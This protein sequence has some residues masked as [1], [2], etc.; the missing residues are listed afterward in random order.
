MA[1]CLCS[2]RAKAVHVML[3]L[4]VILHMALMLSYRDLH[5]IGLWHYG[6][7]HY[8]K[9]TQP[10]FILFAIMLVRLAA[11]QKRRWSL[12]VAPVGILAAFSWR[13]SLTP[14]ARTAPLA[15]NDTIKLPRLDPIDSAIILKG[16][17]GWNE[18][19]SRVHTIDV[20]QLWL[21]DV[22]DFRIYPREND[23]IIVPLRGFPDSPAVLLNASRLRVDPSA[24]IV[25][26]RQT[27][28]FG[29]PCAFGLAGRNLCGAK[30][31]PLIA[32][33]R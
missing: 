20:R 12:L 10:L 18:A 30:G 23:M 9:G 25:S 24:P 16:E 5:I 19:V 26:A 33:E 27:I 22:Y 28:E 29:L 1:A 13:A 6:N 32:R 4:W 15:M 31:A 21:H 3:V 14:V 8:F 17:I 2:G 7:Y 11:D